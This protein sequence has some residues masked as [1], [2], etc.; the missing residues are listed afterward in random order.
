MSTTVATPGGSPPF[1][2]QIESVCKQLPSGAQEDFRTLMRSVISNLQRVSPGGTLLAAGGTKTGSSAPPSGVGFQVAGANGSYTATIRNPSGGSGTIYHEVS[3]SPLKSFTSGVTVMSPTTATSVAVQDPGSS[4]FFRIRSSFDLV[5][6]S[7]YTL[8][9]T[10][11]ISAGKVSSAAT[12]DAGA[13]NQTNYGVVGSTAVGS[14]AE[15]S[16]QGASGPLTNLVTQKGPTQA[17]LPGATIFG[18]TPGSDQFVAH[19]GST[20]VIRPTLA[21]VLADDRN[22]PI[23]AVSVVETGAPTLPVIVPIVSAGGVV[24][25]N[26]TNQGNGI[27]A[28]LD[29]EVSDPGGPGTG[30]TTGQQTIKNGKLISVAPGNA[31]QNYDASTVVTASGGVNPGTPGG[32]T[33]LGG[34]GGRMTAV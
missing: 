15:V 16:V 5:N 28:P 17:S 13:F 26:V 4:Y 20:Y 25:Y 27:S 33:A 1:Q 7:G 29:L 34:N 23:G 19:D 31:G 12:A 9:S 24:G 14:T 11:A 6:W 32:G 30:A 21:G 3:Y 10:A 22:T 8:A 2:S 18:V